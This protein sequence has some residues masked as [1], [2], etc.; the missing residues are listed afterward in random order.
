MVQP[1]LVQIGSDFKGELKK[2]FTRAVGEH[3]VHDPPN[4]Y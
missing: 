4:P 3:H 2:K 1:N